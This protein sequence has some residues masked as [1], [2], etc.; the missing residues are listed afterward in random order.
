MA[1]D[2]T[3]PQLTGD[4]VVTITDIN[5]SVADIGAIAKALS[6]VLT[7]QNA[8]ELGHYIAS[9]ISAN[10]APINYM[11]EPLAPVPRGAQL[12]FWLG[13][14]DDSATVRCEGL[15]FN[16]G[17]GQPPKEQFWTLNTPGPNVLLVELDNS[18]GGPYGMTLHVDVQHVTK[19]GRCI[20][21]EL[22]AGAESDPPFQSHKRNFIYRFT[23]L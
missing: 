21:I 8:R 7:S 19:P 3:K 9:V 1:V 10:N 14:T 18:T 23:V 13:N 15:M 5:A 22:S 16:V 11:P 4:Q 6:D 2:P 20:D 17:R 12:R